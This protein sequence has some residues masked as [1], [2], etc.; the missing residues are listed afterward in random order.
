MP[1]GLCAEA[2]DEITSLLSEKSLGEI[3]DFMG[4]YFSGQPEIAEIIRNRSLI[5]M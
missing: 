4:N 5:M 3:D 2:M 1:Y